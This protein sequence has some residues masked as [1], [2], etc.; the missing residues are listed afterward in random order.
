MKKEKRQHKDKKNTKITKIKTPLIWERMTCEPVTYEQ[1]KGSRGQ[2]VLTKLV[3]SKSSSIKSLLF[4]EKRILS[5]FYEQMILSL[6]FYEQEILS[7]L[8]EQF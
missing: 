7:L 2:L 1:Q 6:L 4:Y 5:L 8:Y 3:Q